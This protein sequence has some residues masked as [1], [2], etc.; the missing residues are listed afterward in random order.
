MNFTVYQIWIFNLYHLCTSFLNQKNTVNW[1]S[2]SSW[3][4]RLVCNF[5]ELNRL[6]ETYIYIYRQLYKSPHAEFTE[7]ACKNL[8]RAKEQANRM[9][10]KSKRFIKNTSKQKPLCPIKRWILP[11]TPRSLQESLPSGKFTSC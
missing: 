1:K 7:N 3:K 10:Q 2:H 6:F 4:G 9:I 11:I 5:E 8:P